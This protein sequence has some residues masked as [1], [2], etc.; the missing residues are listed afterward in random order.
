MFLFPF[1][2]TCVVTR[3][4]LNYQN[5]E[6]QLKSVDLL[7]QFGA[8]EKVGVACVCE[9]VV[10]QVVDWIEH[11]RSDGAT[12]L[13]SLTSSVTVLF[14]KMSWVCWL[15]WTFFFVSDWN[16]YGKDLVVASSC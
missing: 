6:L 8:D 3:T 5:T 12:V 15:V 4:V 9:D 14:F 1:V 13:P 7:D 16:H 2:Q 11:I 10:E